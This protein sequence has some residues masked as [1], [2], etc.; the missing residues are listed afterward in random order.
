MSGF[1]VKKPYTI[2][3]GV[4]IVLVLGI[5]SFTNLTTDLLPSMELPYVAI[6]TTYPGSS[7]EKVEESVSKV[8]EQGM[9]GISNIE[10]VTSTSSENYSMVMLEFAGDSNMDSV[11][12]EISQ[13]LDVLEANLEDGV[14]TPTVMQINPDMM[15]VLMSAV[16]MEHADSSQITEFVEKTLIP[17]LES[18]E[19]VA[20]VDTYG[21]IQDEITIKLDQAKI[22][23]INDKMLENVSRELADKKK[24]LDKAQGQ[25]NTGKAELEA[26]KAEKTKE[27]ADGLSAIETGRNEITKAEIELHTKETELNTTKT[28]LETNLAQLTAAETEMATQKQEL[29]TALAALNTQID[30]LQTQKTALETRKAELEAKQQTGEITGAELIELMEITNHIIKIET[31]LKAI[32]TNE[33]YTAL[34]AG[35]EQINQK[36]AEVTAGKEQLTTGLSQITAGLSQM[37]EAKNTINSKKTELETTSS[38]LQ[39]AQSTLV[40]ETTKA[41]TQLETAEKEL[42]AGKEQ[43]EDAREEAYK[44]ASLDGIITTDLISQILTAENFS[45]PAG[46]INDDMTV[47][48]GEKFASLEEI[49][50]LILFTFDM[51]GLEEIKLADVA[52]IELTNNSD[53]VYAKVNENNGIVLAFSKQ[54]TASTK[55]VSEA[56][57]EKLGELEEKYDEISFTNLMDQGIYIDM[58]IGSVMQSLVVGGILAIFILLLFLKEI[59]PTLIIAVSIPVSLVFAIAMMYFTGV[60]INIMSLSGLALGVGM[61]VD[62]SIVVIENIY[63]LRKEGK[64]TK[65]AAIEGAKKVTGAIIASTLTTVCVFLPI[66][67]VQGMSRQIFEDIGLTIAYSLIAS[68]IVAL[69]V[70]P[71]MASKMF[72]KVTEKENKFIHKISELYA[73]LLGGALK[74]KAIVIILVIVLL[75]TSIF[76][77]TKMDIEFIPSVASDEMSISITMPQNSTTEEMRKVSDTVIQRMLEISDIQKIG[78]IDNATGSMMGGSNA[79]GT[80]MYI[81]LGEERTMTSDEIA[82]KIKELT[83]DLNCELEISTSNMDMSAM[84]AS[85]ISL[86]ITGNNLDKLKEIA[87]DVESKLLTVEGIDEVEGIKENSAKEQRI[88]VDKNKAMKYGL[89]IAQIYATISNEIKTELEGTK[90]EIDNKEYQVML[91]KSDADVINIDNLMKIELEGKFNN[92]EKTIAL[93]EVASVEESTGLESITRENNHRYVTVVANV[94]EGASMTQVSRAVENQFKDYQAPEG[95]RVEIEGEMDST[96]EYV[97]DLMLMIAVAILFIYLIMVAQFQSFKLPFIVMFTIPLAFTGG[98]LALFMTGTPISII[99]ILGFLVLAGI[100]VNNGIVFIDCVNQFVE[101]GMEKIEAIQLT[102]KLRLRPILMT[103]LTT[104]LGLLSMALGIGDGAEMTQPLGI[105]A[106]G[107]LVYATLLTLFLVPVLYDLFYRKKKK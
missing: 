56:I 1:S 73:N 61:L 75:G 103:A 57:Q 64:D 27:I 5:V 26:T 87:T 11:M 63:R 14:G 8:I 53:E 18:V 44:N 42:K 2:F 35:L 78:A 94:K 92:E 70:V 52:T 55:N 24:E 67:F 17:E 97:G 13:E 60:T 45:M 22:D 16:D 47:K 15:P 81:L 83:A 3:V 80:S 36:Q 37:N 74:F 58:I 69:T 34:T 106:I 38:M 33:N 79:L 59:K 65:E 96:M 76:M 62:N 19:G 66:V 89:T 29:E 40:S 25:I 4:V 107:G 48:V 32:Q 104:I 21:A 72:G 39:V 31:S 98:I 99:A 49:Q 30:E 77:T 51:K 41:A 100:V 46:Y 12:I 88:K 10:N 105:V 101:E 71:A 90:I 95:Y 54:S 85:G 9:M 93:S 23:T 82:T 102:G 86:K 28:E 20:S 84:M 7:P 91:Q 43:F 6:I 68:L 50:N